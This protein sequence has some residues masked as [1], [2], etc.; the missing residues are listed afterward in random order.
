TFFCAR[1]CHTPPGA[2]TMTSLLHRPLGQTAISVSALGLGT[3]KLGRH[4]GMK[5]PEAYPVPSDQQAAGLLA[6]ARAGGINLLD[7]APAYGSSEERLGQLLKGQRQHWVLCSK[8][9]EEFDGQHSH[10]DFS[11]EHTRMSIER[12]LRRLG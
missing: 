4:T 3:V 9:G 7:T 12:S 6:V 8:V 10:F 2:N 5:Y 1:N 11:A